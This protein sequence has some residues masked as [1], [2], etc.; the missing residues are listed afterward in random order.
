MS[1]HFQSFASATRGSSWFLKAPVCKN[2]LFSQTGKNNENTTGNWLCFLCV[3]CMYLFLCLEKT[4][5]HLLSQVVLGCPV[6]SG[7]LWP[8]GL[9]STR[10]LCSWDSPGKN[11]GVGCH[12]ISLKLDDNY[13]AG[14]SLNKWHH[15]SGNVFPSLRQIYFWCFIY[16]SISSL[17]VICLNVCHHRQVLWSFTEQEL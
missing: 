7:S 11:T 4:L 6:V 9:S 2:W 3:L 5:P 13:S 8:H 12:A 14:L 17:V 1:Y 15:I 16:T 10:L